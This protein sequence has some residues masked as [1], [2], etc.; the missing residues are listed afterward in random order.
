[1]TKSQDLESKSKNLFPN[2]LNSPYAI[3]LGP[4]RETA[5]SI[6]K[7]LGR[8]DATFMMI[9]GEPRSKA[10]PQSSTG[11]R[12]DNSKQHAQASLLKHYM[13]TCILEPIQGNV[14]I[15]CIFYRSSKTRIDLD[16]LI[17]EV[18][19]SANGIIWRD[20]MQ[21]TACVGILRM[22]AKFPRT[23]IAVG[24][25]DIGANLD[26]SN[27]DIPAVCKT[28]GNDFVWRKYPCSKKVGHFCSMA[29]KNR[30]GR[31]DLRAPA[32]CRFCQKD[33]M[34]KVGAQVFCSDDCRTSAMIQRNKKGAI[35]PSF[36]QV[37]GTKVSR[38]EYR[39]CRACFKQNSR[40]YG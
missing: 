34:R 23:A 19:D 4:D 11:K 5:L 26:R 17:K 24:A 38:P 20:D 14:A 30:F 9:E 3:R 12:Y 18:C 13:K 25:H 37:C 32:N 10:R 35:G 16:N 7:T 1:M 28:C 27:Q 2:I 29:C 36:C 40:R 31:A 22:D 6:F 8:G 33:F 21:V 15:V 39:R